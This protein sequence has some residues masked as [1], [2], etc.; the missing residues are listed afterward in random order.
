MGLLTSITM[1][2]VEGTNVY[3]TEDFISI[4]IDKKSGEVIFKG[5]M[6]K[7]L[8]VIHLPLEKLTDVRL[9]TEKEIIEKSKSVVGRAAL[10]TI[11]AGPLGAVI[12]GMSG[13]GSKKKDKEKVILT[14]DYTDGSLIFIADKHISITDFYNR[15]KKYMPLAETKGG[16]ITL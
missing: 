6:N 12:G 3:K 9:E 15:L 14:V 11:V 16:H 5:F 4:D 10:G 2:F 7:K 8:P 1:Q 13:I